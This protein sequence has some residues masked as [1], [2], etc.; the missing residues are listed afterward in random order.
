MSI[1]SQIWLEVTY[2]SSPMIIQTVQCLEEEEKEEEDDDEEEHEEEK[3]EE[4]KTEQNN[5]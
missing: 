4:T 3:E 1:L 5:P 2:F